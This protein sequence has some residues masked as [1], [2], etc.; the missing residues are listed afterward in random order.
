MK[1]IYVLLAA[2][3]CGIQMI[4]AGA[5][6]TID[7]TNTA[8]FNPRPDSL[9]CV[10]RNFPYSQVLQIKVPTSVDLATFGLGFSF[11]LS[12][13]SVVFD[14]I[15]GL[16]SGLSYSMNPPGGHLYGGNH[17]CAVLFGTTSDPTGNYPLIFHGTITLHGTPYPPIFDG[18]TTIDLE[19]IQSR[20]QNPFRAS[21]D[22]INQ[23]DACRPVQSG[24]NDFSADLNSLIQIYPNPGN[25]I[26]ELRLNAGRRIKGEVVVV[27]IT[28]QKVYSQMIDAVGLYT[29][30]INLLQFAKGLYTLQIRTAEGFASKNISIE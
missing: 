6:C 24:I 22:V 27:D 15:T 5:N 30:G 16:P 1:K 19:T 26:F 23:G 13:D 20:P 14:S 8:F 25:G 9:P 21:V 17:A 10:E 12:V 18:D 7:S 2:V 3:L 29:T 28:G 11:I 4:F